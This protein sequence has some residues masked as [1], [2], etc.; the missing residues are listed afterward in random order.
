MDKFDL[1]DGIKARLF[2][3]FCEEMN[4][5]RILRYEHNINDYYIE[6]VP[7]FEWKFMA[8]GESNLK[9][10]IYNTYKDNLQENTDDR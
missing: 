10:A 7:V 1:S 3:L 9:T 2:D 4:S 6:N 5:P 8:V